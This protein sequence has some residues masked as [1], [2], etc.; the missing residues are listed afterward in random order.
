MNLNERKIVNMFKSF[1]E[2][3]FVPQL[4]KMDLSCQQEWNKFSNMISAEQ[5]TLGEIQLYVDTLPG[6]SSTLNRP[7][8][9]PTDNKPNFFTKTKKE[10][11]EESS[12]SF[13]PSKTFGGERARMMFPLKD[14]DEPS[15]DRQ[16]YN[17]SKDFSKD[18]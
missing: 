18:K 3:V 8:F 9:N 12:G 2:R 7:N 16:N 17:F 10:P 1:I 5:A 4:P 6:T 15:A 11:V 13:N 14:F